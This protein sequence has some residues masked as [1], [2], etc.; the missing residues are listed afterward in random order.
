[1][2]NNFG[3]TED[4]SVVKKDRICYT[5]GTMIKTITVAG[6]PL[7]NYTVRESLIQV[8]K[9]MSDFG[10]HTIEEVN[11]EMLMKA[12][13]DEAL[14]K[15][16]FSMEHTVIAEN[17]ILDVMEGGSYQRTH[18]IA[19]HDFFFEF[20]RRMERNQKTIFL[21]G[22]TMGRVEEMQRFMLNLFPE[23]RIV[24]VA[25]L[26]QWADSLDTMINDINVLSPNVLLS[27]LPSPLQEHFLMENKSKLS[28]N[29]WYGVGNPQYLMMETG[30]KRKFREVIGTRKLRKYLRGIGK[31]VESMR[32]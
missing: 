22:E 3:L 17:A 12:S 14:R 8:E 27:V 32:V 11:T 31:H 20:M 7:D 30:W 23:S 5:V 1:M 24:G 2:S 6:I 16:L 19:H 10:F 28:A 4:L 29:L 15:A 25:A 26:E 9:D 13:G 21:L 18:E